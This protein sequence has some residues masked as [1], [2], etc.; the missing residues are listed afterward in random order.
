MPGHGRVRSP[1]TVTG[2]SCS[3]SSTPTPSSSRSTTS[4]V[5]K[6]SRRGYRWSNLTGRSV[7]VPA[8]RRRRGLPDVS[9]E[10][11][12]ERALVPIIGHRRP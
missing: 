5:A 6:A 9:P 12:L 1:P 4:Q 8:P 2:W 3:S 11:G 10:P 7:D